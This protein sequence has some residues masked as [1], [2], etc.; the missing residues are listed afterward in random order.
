M[1]DKELSESDAYQVIEELRALG[2]PFSSLDDLVNKPVND[3]L[4]IEVLSKHI[5][6]PYPQDVKEWFIR[7]VSLRAGRGIIGGQL[8]EEFKNSSDEDYKWVI[9]NAIEVV[10]NDELVPSILEMMEGGTIGSGYQM[11]VLALGKVKKPAL[12][13]RTIKLLEKLLANENVRGH[14][15][16]SLGKL[17]AIEVA[18]SIEPFTKHKNSYIAREATKALKKINKS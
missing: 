11:V 8:L 1:K 16:F 4:V 5:A 7:A 2:F 18:S 6:K 15:I 12:R 10:I 17:K 14:A 13:L 3:R 9:G